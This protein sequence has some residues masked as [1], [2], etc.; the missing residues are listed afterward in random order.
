MAQQTSGPNP[1]QQNAM[2]RQMLM[3][4]SP[5]MVKKVGTFTGTLGGN[6]R[7]KLFNVGLITRLMLKVTV[8]TTIGTATAT[9]GPKGLNALLSR[10]KLVDFDGSDRVNATGF[11]LYQRNSLRRRKT[12]TFGYANVMSNVSNNAATTAVAPGETFP[13]VNGAVGTNNQVAF[14]EVP[15]CRDV[16]AG[17]LRGI[18]LAQTTVGELSLSIDWASAAFANGDDDRVFNGA[19]TTTVAVNSISVDVYQ[20]YFLP[21]AIQG[22]VPIPQI[23]TMTV[24][25]LSGGVRTSDNIAAGTEKLL[26]LPN[27]RQIHGVYASYLNNSRLGGSAFAND[28]SQ[29]RLIANGNNVLREYEILMQYQEQRQYL[30]AD[31]PRGTY[32]MDFST[33]PLQTNLYGNI[34][35]GFTPAGTVT[36]G[37]NIEVMYESCY[38]KGQALSGLSQSG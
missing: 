38:V 10:V 20:E 16:E 13:I 15:V 31:L 14:V 35:M 8:N 25:E 17:D 28:M 7:V 5:L 12:S 29:I 32:F 27:V 21:Q 37:A 11:Q 6:T 9:L 30:G 33:S 3:Q 23:D 2:M 1:G 24:Y 22:I 34:Q 36:A 18:I 4:S 26:S 19:A